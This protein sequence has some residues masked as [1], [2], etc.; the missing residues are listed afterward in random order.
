MITKI[1]KDNENTLCKKSIYIT[2][3]FQSEQMMTQIYKFD[4][5]GWNARGIYNFIRVPIP[6]VDDMEWKEIGV[7]IYYRIRHKFKRIPSNYFDIA[8]SEKVFLGYINNMM[9]IL[10]LVD[11]GTLNN[12][13]YL[14]WVKALHTTGW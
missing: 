9:C 1:L 6:Y 8:N 10:K 7:S 11:D 12:F 3:L 13:R 14:I 4:V 5:K 2:N